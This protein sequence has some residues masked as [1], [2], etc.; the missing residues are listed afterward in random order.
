MQHFL[1]LIINVSLSLILVQFFGIA[2]IAFATFIAYLFE[3]IYLSVVV[4]KNLNVSLSEYIPVKI[5]SIYSVTILVIFV[6]VNMFFE[7]TGCWILDTRC[8][9]LDT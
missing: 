3:K 8:W 7:N 5:Y 6:L 2:G 1:E 9:I 4:K